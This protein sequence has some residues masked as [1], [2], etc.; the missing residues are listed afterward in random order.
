MLAHRNTFP[1]QT[2]TGLAGFIVIPSGDLDSKVHGFRH[3]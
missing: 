3:R 2:E 1:V